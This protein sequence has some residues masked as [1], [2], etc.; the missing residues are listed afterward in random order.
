M[1]EPAMQ[2]DAIELRCPGTL[3]ALLKDGL[4]EVKC[5]HWRCTQGKD[6]SVFHLYDPMTGDLVRTEYYKDPVKRGSKT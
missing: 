1:A 3:H 6:V 4:I 2:V 5:H